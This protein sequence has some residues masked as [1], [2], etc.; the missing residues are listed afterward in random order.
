MSQL[1]INLSEKETYIIEIPEKLQED[2]FMILL[3][4]L[5]KISRF[6][7]KD[8]SRIL[9]KNAPSKNENN[10]IEKKRDVSTRKKRKPSRPIPQLKD[11][12]FILSMLKLHYFGKEEDKIKFEKD[13]N[14]SWNN[15]VKRFTV[16]KERHQIKP[17]EIGLKK[18]PTQAEG[19]KKIFYFLDNENEEEE[20]N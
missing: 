1:K 17:Y 20:N 4:R 8:D 14:Y 7:Q 5:N 13:F 6:I 16:L 10:T 3:E 18:F 12:N 19:R 11:R 2:E 15:L 9:L